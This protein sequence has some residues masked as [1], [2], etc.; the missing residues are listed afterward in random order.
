MVT[1]AV[2]NELSVC[3]DVVRRGDLIF[4]PTSL[5]KKVLNL[6]H[7]GHQSIVKIKKRL[8]LKVWWPGIE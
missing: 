4:V 1:K 6:A 5:R 7:S 2:R 8:R 3:D